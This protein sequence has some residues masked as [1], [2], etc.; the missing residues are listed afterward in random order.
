LGNLVTSHVPNF[1]FLTVGRQS[2]S[3]DVSR[4]RD[5]QQTRLFYREETFSILMLNAWELL[6]KAKLVAD[7]NNDPRCIYVYE[8]RQTKLGRLSKKLYVRR[9]RSG[10]NLT[11]SLAKCLVELDR[12]ATTRVPSAVK[13]NLEGLIA[14]RDSAIHYL[15]ATPRLAKRVLEIGTASV[16]NFIEL[17]KRWFLIDFAFENLYLMPIGFVSAPGAA[18]A[19]ATTNDEDKL[20]RF[21]ADLVRSSASDAGADFH[22]ALE[23][24]LS[25]KRAPTEAVA[26]VRVTS[27]PEAPSVTIREE[28]IRSR[29]P[30]DYEQL[31]RKLRQRYI[32][33]MVNKKFHEVRKP[34]LADNRYSNSRFLDPGNPRSAKKD[35]YNPNILNEFDKHYTRTTASE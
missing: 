1:S 31:T 17:G 25:F 27:D 21:L 8:S 10:H 33:F 6:L 11:L 19:I 24:N 20:V 13:S 30:W 4:N 35:F 15:N 23:V 26:S 3:G 9:N 29:Y 18:T 14:I 28:D 12:R 32:D 2:K 5:L 34:L 7:N 16:K 22:V